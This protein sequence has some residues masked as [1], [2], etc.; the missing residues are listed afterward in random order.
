ME[1]GQRETYRALDDAL[2][3]QERA[4]RIAQSRGDRDRL[5]RA[6]E[7]VARAYDTMATLAGL[8]T[9]QDQRDEVAGKV[10]R[11]FPVLVHSGGVVCRCHTV[12][13]DDAAWASHIGAVMVP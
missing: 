1:A 10:M 2:A 6:H 5:R 8:P 7:V 4:A 13:H 12:L 9:R 3:E 11:H